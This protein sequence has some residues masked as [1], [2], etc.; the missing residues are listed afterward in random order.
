MTAVPADFRRFTQVYAEGWKALASL[1]GDGVATRLY[2]FLAEA[3]GADNAVTAKTETLAK[4][5]GV[6]VRTIERAASRLKAGRHVV[7][8]KMGSINVYV[9]NP[10]EVWKS[11]LKGRHFLSIRTRALVGL[12]DNPSIESLFNSPVGQGSLLD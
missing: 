8:L 10:A 12:D 2:V 4:E 9:L 3:A 1:A 5:L 6:S 11:A 7:V